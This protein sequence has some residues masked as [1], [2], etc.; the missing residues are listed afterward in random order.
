MRLVVLRQIYTNLCHIFKQRITS[1]KSDYYCAKIES[2]SSNT[3]EYH[4]A[5]DLMGR[6]RQTVLPKCDGVW[7]GWILRHLL[8]WQDYC[9]CLTTS[10]SLNQPFV[11]EPSDCHIEDPLCN[12]TLATSDDIC[13]SVYPALPVS[14]GRDTKSRWSLLSGVYPRGSKSSPAG[15]KCVTCRWLHILEKDNSE[16]NLSYVSHIQFIYKELEYII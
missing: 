14:F 7:I 16:I 12:F 1:A 11:F 15:G 9:S 2:S 8:R 13:N 10:R 4:M 3:Q 6:T 5:N